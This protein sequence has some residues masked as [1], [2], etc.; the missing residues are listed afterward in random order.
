MELNT[1]ETSDHANLRR[2]WAVLRSH[3]HLVLVARGS[4][5]SYLWQNFSK[6]ETR[7]C[8]FT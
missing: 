5:N 3:T 8:R 4:V 1:G 6:I 7:L 2:N